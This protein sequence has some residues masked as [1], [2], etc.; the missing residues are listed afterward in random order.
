M[1]SVLTSRTLWESFDP[2]AEQLDIDPIK[3]S[4]QG[5]I[6]TKQ[7]YFTGRTLPSGAKTRVFAVLCYKKTAE[8]KPAVLVIGNY[9]HPVDMNILRDLAMRGFVAMAVDLAGK[10]V[11]GLHTVYPEE[12]LYCNDADALSMFEIPET[13]RETKLY[14][15]TV[16]CR[17]AIT[18][19]LGEEG[20]SQV[21]VLTEGRGAYVGIIV[22]G[23]ETRVTNGA[24]LFGNLYRNFPI[25][26]NDENVLD[27]G[28]DELERHIAYDTRRQQW[29]LGLAPQTYAQQIKVPVYVV[30]SANSPFVDIVQTSKTMMRLNA[31]SR[32]LIL[33]T[34]MDYLP[35]RYTDGVLAWL[36]GYE[37]KPKSEIKS[38]RNDSGDYCISVTADHPLNKTSL[39][40][41]TDAESR[42]KHWTKATLAQGQ[43]GY[44]AK[45]NLYE[46]ECNVAAFA[47]FEDDVS[48]STLLLTEKVAVANVIKALNIIFS[49]TGKQTLVPLVTDGSW[50]NVD[51]EPQLDKG[52]LNILGAKGRALATFAINDK[53]I[54]INQAF[55]VVFDVYCTVRQQIKLVAV[56][57]FGDVN[58]Q[59]SQY[60]QV[61]GNGKWEHVAFDKINFHREGDGKQLLDSEKVEMLVIYADNE[62]LVN[63]IFLV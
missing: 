58:M 39:W 53:S 42:A 26:G 49:G 4:E 33:P 29:T 6:V 31:E 11:K 48:S 23:V 8:G 25:L 34:S 32:L 55:T 46:K 21:S 51:L 9:A 38:F 17:R 7:L 20:V 57:K 37:A 24:I 10:R 43:N 1:E 19:L 60:A 40:Y 5:G 18:Y 2:A 15:Y 30:N 12:I 50:W 61:A 13:A 56:T 62:F 35:K 59:Y 41:C 47:T 28:K 16:S 22:L 14:E 45:L 54:R 63:N 27:A 44:V 52:Y 36:R 3:R